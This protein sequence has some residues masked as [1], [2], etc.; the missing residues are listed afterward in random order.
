VVAVVAALCTLG[1]APGEVGVVA[2]YRAQVA[3]IRRQIALVEAAQGSVA[4]VTVDTVDRFQGGEREVM[5]LSLTGGRSTAA[6]AGH[7]DF[8]ADPRRLNVALTR[9]RSKLI[10]VGDLAVLS[11][12]PVLRDL[13]AH[14]H[15]A[16]CIVRWPS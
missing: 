16:G 12:L 11:W 9:A 4:G 6:H 1:I 13:V 15:G 10:V 14:C 7:A 5:V 3:L 2:P 8:L